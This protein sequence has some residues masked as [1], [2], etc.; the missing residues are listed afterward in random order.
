MAPLPESATLEQVDRHEDPG[1]EM[2]RRGVRMQDGTGRQGW[3]YI[4]LGSL[5]GARRPVE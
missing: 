2:V 4:F 3:V 5:A 1:Y